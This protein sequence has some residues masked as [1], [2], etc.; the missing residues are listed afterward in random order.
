M[1]TLAAQEKNRSKSKNNKST[2]NK[3]KSNP[4]NNSNEKKQKMN[5]EGDEEKKS[6]K[7]S[8]RA[9][10]YLK[11]PNQANELIN[12]FYESGVYPS[13]LHE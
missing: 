11:N 10:R 7:N 3:N 1:K 13:K 4:T 2:S 9:E 5:S 12:K 8:L 6:Y